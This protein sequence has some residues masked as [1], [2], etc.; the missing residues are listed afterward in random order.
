MGV[1]RM[2]N[3]G[4]MPVVIVAAAAAGTLTVVNLRG[5][6]GADEIFRWD[7]SG[8]HVIDSIN[9]KQV[10]YEVF[11]AG[12]ASGTVSY[13]NRD[14]QPEQCARTSK[15]FHHKG[16]DM[17]LDHMAGSRSARLTKR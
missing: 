6:F 17:V 1:R 12:T 4:W 11:G 14:A 9:E 2:V 10:R 16:V 7:G 5:A 3:R 13:L 15:N 8:S